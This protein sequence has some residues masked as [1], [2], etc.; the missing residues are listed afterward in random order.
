MILTKRTK[1]RWNAKN[2][3]RF[4]ELGYTYT[5]MKDEFEVNIEHLSPYSKAKIE[6]QCD[7][8]KD[9]YK[10]TFE[11]HRKILD[12]S[13]DVLKH[14]CN[15]EQCRQSKIKE[16]NNVRYGVDYFIALDSTREQIKKTCLENY[17]VENPFE[18]KK[19][20][21]QIVKTNID[22][23]GVESFTQTEAYIKQSQATSLERYG[24]THYTKT[25]EYKELYGG[26]NS[27]SWKGGVKYHRNERATMEYRDWRKSVFDSDFYTCQKCNVKSGKLNAHHI[28]NWKDNPT[29][30]F[31]KSNGITLCEECHISFHSQYGKVE[32]DE[33]QLNRFL[34]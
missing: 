5:K 21:E 11:N 32:N 15:K 8:C 16:V 28:C 3:K 29:L 22:K 20:Q 18:S 17:G 9:V 26:E 7:Y 24:V 19:I 1:V 31:E 33:G 10:S 30:R 13:S 6:I 25:D 34:K 2:K 14:C 4:V 27:P 12:N 23:Y